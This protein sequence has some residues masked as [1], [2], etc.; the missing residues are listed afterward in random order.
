MT[1]DDLDH[2]IEQARDSV[3]QRMAQ[4]QTQFGIGAGGRYEL[5]LPSATIRFFDADDHP[6]ATARIQVAGS[7]SPSGKSWMWGWANESLPA[8]VTE[9]L[10]A[11]R[12]RG[13]RDGLDSLTAAVVASEEAD[14]WT[15]ASLAADICQAACVYRAAGPKSQLFLLLFDLRSASAS[16]NT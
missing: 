10:A 15:L 11:V 3:R 6:R 13:E 12:E 16:D 4:A 8:A 9:A 14:A 2:W 5:D 7:W 1:D